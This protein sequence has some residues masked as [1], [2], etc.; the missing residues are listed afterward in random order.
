MK[1]DLVNGKIHKLTMFWSENMRGTDH[2]G[3]LIMWQNN[4]KTEYKEMQGGSW[5]QSLIRL[6]G[7]EGQRCSHEGIRTLKSSCKQSCNVWEYQL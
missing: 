1:Q 3:E 6:T 2:V 4:I 7:A 5:P